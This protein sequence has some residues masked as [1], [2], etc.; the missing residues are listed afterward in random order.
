[1]RC[2]QS[3]RAVPHFEERQLIRETLWNAG[4]DAPVYASFPPRLGR[5]AAAPA[6]GGEVSLHADLNRSGPSTLPE[7]AAAPEASESPPRYFNGVL[8]PVSRSA[9]AATASFLAHR[10]RA[11]RPTLTRVFA[12][13]EMAEACQRLLKLKARPALMTSLLGAAA[14]PSDLERVAEAFVAL[15]R[16]DTRQTMT[17][18]GGSP[19]PKALDLVDLADG[20]IHALGRVS[21][22]PYCVLLFVAFLDPKQIRL[23]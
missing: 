11:L 7:G 12:H 5:P 10:H 4:W 6:D 1:M 21:S 22:D 23:Q 17:S 16:L 8:W 14:L 20:A 15:Q 18:R 13:R 2:L 3:R 19:G 9:F